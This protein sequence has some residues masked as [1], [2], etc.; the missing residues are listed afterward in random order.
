V[1]ADLRFQRAGLG[2]TWRSWSRGEFLFD[3]H[4]SACIKGKP[5]KLGKIRKHLEE[6]GTN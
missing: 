3:G 1:A 4:F 6:E 5:N 2:L